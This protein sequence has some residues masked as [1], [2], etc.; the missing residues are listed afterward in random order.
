MT[1]ESTA[2]GLP[3]F[4]LLSVFATQTKFLK[5]SGYCSVTNWIF[6]FCT[7][8]SF[9]YFCI[10]TYFILQLSDLTQNEAIHNILLHLLPWYYQLQCVPFMAWT[11]L[12]RWCMCCKL[13]CTKILQNFWLTLMMCIGPVGCDWRIY[14]LHLCR[15]VRFPQLVSW[16]WH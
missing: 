16:I 10:I 13:T 2:L 12:V 7:T 1:S 3:V 6:I 5:S 4:A 15:I 9:D 11:A 14:R 8:N